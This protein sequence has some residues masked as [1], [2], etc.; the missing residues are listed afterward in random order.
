VVITPK[1]GLDSI[2]LFG[3]AYPEA[4]AYPPEIRPQAIVPLTP[5]S[6]PAGQRYVAEGPIR[7]DYYFSPTYTPT[8]EGS[9]KQ[10]VVGQTLYYQ[11][12]YNH[13]FAYVR[14]SDVD[15]VPADAN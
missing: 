6:I 1:A 5:Y 12:S 3:R 13:R 14:A 11:V 8:V 2:P 7:S 9:N 15:V 10:V 4:A